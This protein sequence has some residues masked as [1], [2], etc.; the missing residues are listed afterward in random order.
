MVVI[1]P[2]SIKLLTYNSDSEEDKMTDNFEFVRTNMVEN[3]KIGE[4]NLLMY[5]DR[6]NDK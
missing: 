2:L 5:L 1:D 6:R 3:W 4:Q